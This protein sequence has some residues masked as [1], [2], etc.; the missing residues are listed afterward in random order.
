M[1]PRRRFGSSRIGEAKGSNG[2]SRTYLNDDDL[3]D[4]VA[5]LVRSGK[6]VECATRLEGAYHRDVRVLHLS[7]AEAQTLLD[8]LGECPA[9]LLS[10]RSAIRAALGSK[11]AQ[12]P[13]ARNGHDRRAG[14]VPADA[15]IGAS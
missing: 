5:R 10:L 9:R 8:V 11:S 12:S 1:P 15:A 14:I 3:F 2:R 4:L 6:D 7:A 13:H